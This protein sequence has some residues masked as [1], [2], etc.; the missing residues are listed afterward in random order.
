MHSGCFV[1][2]NDTGSLAGSIPQVRLTT[3]PWER[4]RG[5]LGRAPLQ[6]GEGLW[7]NACSSVHSMGMG[8]ALDL[9]YLDAGLQVLRLVRDFKPWRLSWRPGASSVIELMAGSLDDLGIQPGFVLEWQRDDES[10]KCS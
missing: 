3:N 2:K 9:V 4:A 10:R 5:L 8:Y 6:A 1:W 7:I